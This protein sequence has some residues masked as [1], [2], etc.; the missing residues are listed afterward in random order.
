MN[1]VGYGHSIPADFVDVD[2]HEFEDIVAVNVTAN[3][4]VTHIILPMMIKRNAK[5]GKNRGLIINVG[6]FSGAVPIPMLQT[7][8]ATKA[9]LATFSTAL[10]EEVKQHRIT[11]EHL[12]AYFI[13]NNLSPCCTP[14]IAH[15]LSCLGF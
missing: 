3:L 14:K 7:Y 2:R 9:F 8:S 10:A 6:S 15:L 1:N 5:S 13:V 11:V 12:N 4:R